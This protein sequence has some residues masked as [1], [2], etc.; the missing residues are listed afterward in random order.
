MIA[1]REMLVNIVPLLCNRRSTIVLE[2]KGATD[3][4][5]CF[6]MLHLHSA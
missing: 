6:R 4:E 3:L 5:L 2:S 1:H